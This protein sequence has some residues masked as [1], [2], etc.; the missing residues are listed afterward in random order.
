[1]LGVGTITKD[2]LNTANFNVWSIKDIQIIINHF[3][4][5]PLVT[6]KHYDYLIFKQCFEIIKNG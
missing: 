5:Y 2:K 1:M 4:K 3:D 6:A